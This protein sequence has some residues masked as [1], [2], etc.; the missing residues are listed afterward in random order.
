MT[1]TQILVPSLINNRNLDKLLG[2][3]SIS[4]SCN[5]REMLWISQRITKMEWTPVWRDQELL[6]VY[7]RHLL[8]VGFLQLMWVFLGSGDIA[9]WLVYLPSM[10]CFPSMHWLPAVHKSYIVAPTYDP[11]TKKAGKKIQKQEVQGHPWLHNRF[12]TSFSYIEFKNS[13][14][15]IRWPP[16]QKQK[17]CFNC[18]CPARWR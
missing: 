18:A 1:Y 17:E 5:M 15:D 14:G 2:Q 10:Y 6:L 3:S 11:S 13:L 7:N 16:S 12:K 4:V 9:P 8:K